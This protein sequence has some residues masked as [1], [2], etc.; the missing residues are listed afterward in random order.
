MFIIPMSGGGLISGIST[1]IKER[2]PQIKIIGVETEAIHDFPRVEKQANLW[3]CQLKYYCRW[4][5]TAST[6]NTYP[7]IEGR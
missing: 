6:G 3:K 5:K 4:L 1:A 7:I 2:M